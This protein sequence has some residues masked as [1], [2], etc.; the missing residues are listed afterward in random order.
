MSTDHPADDPDTEEA[1]DGG[2]AADAGAGPD[3]DP[4]PEREAAVP[5][6]E[7][8]E[9]RDRGVDP[10]RL[11][12]LLGDAVLRRDDHIN[13]DAAFEIR[14]DAVQDTLETLRREAG[15]DHLS[16]VTAQQYADRYESIYHL[17]Q[18][19]DPTREVSVVVPAPRSSPSHESAAPVFRT[20]DWHEREAYDLLGVRYDDHPDLRRILLP[21]TWQGHP[22][23]EDYD[24]DRPQIVTL[25]EHANPLQEDHAAEEGD[26][27]FLNIGPHHPATHGVLHL[28]TTLDGEQVADVEPD[29]GYLHR[30]EE[31]MAQQGTYRHQIM[32]YPDRWD[33]ISAGLL[34]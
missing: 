33:Y 9:V 31:Q 15:F 14:P 5:E 30:C 13:A 16:C 28:K 26:T 12:G 27:M 3:P 32:P 22:L 6:Q 4:D 34:N 24:R 7:A 18:Y 21:E 2:S 19:D 17:K 8:V 23:A 10:D 20:A 29:I 1:T 11:E 25:E